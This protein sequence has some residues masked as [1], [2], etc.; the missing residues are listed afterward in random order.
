MGKTD[1]CG[2]AICNKRDLLMFIAT[3]S[4]IV[5]VIRP[6]CTRRLDFAQSDRRLAR[7]LDKCGTAICDRSHPDV[8]GA[9][10]LAP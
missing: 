2:T 9:R 1:T 3:C 5:P 10:P 8:I 4:A 7:R 6:D